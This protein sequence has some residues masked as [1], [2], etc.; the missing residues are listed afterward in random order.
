MIEIGKELPWILACS[1]AVIT[2][3]PVAQ[4]SCR[5]RLYTPAASVRSSAP[6]VE[7]ASVLSGVNSSPTPIPWIALAAANQNSPPSSGTRDISTSAAAVMTS[8]VASNAR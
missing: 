4:P 7:K 8:P 2:A 1:T 6:R 5:N 3:T